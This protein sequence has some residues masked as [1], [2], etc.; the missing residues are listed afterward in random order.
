MCGPLL[1]AA[2]TQNSSTRVARYRC[3]QIGQA[4]RRMEQLPKDGWTSVGVENQHG[5]MVDESR[6]IAVRFESRNTMGHIHRLPQVKC[7]KAYGPGLVVP[8]QKGQLCYDG[9]ADRQMTKR[10]VIWLRC[11]GSFCCRII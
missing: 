10:L 6:N 4:S 11:R 1:R 3:T 5:Q 9:Q 8:G 2:I 7:I